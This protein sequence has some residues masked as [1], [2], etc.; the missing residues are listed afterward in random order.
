MGQLGAE[1]EPGLAAQIGQD[2]IR[3]L[4]FYDL[5]H[6]FQIE[7]LDIGDVGHGRSVMMVAGLEL[8]RTIL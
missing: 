5:G 2:G 1:V 8:T 4:L 6:P 7:G 3:P